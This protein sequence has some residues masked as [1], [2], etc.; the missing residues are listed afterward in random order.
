[1]QKENESPLPYSPSLEATNKT[2]LY[3][4]EK[5]SEL[6]LPLPTQVNKKKEDHPS[7]NF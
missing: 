5:N 2:L 3:T 1:M 4:L 7:S 6:E